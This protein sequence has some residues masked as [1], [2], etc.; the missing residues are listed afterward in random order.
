MTIKHTCQW[1]GQ[2][3]SEEEGKW[4]KVGD[5]RHWLCFKCMVAF[6]GING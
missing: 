5:W 6:G 2:D 3:K 1:C 4:T